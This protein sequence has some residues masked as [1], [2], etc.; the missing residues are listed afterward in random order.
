M[1]DEDKGLL[2][3]SEFGTR[4]E[5]IKFLKNLKGYARA[6]PATRD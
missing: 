3:F 1:P 2:F 5:E 6:M 4:I